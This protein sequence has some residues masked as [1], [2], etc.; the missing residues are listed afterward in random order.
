MG[1]RNHLGVFHFSW[2]KT[3]EV[4]HRAFRRQNQLE[5]A[6]KLL[7]ESA[8]ETSEVL[9]MP[10]WLLPFVLLVVLTAPGCRSAPASAAPI[11]PSPHFAPTVVRAPVA[12]TRSTGT[13]VTVAVTQNHEED[14]TLVNL[15]APD[16]AVEPLAMDGGLRVRG[17]P[18]ADVL[19]RRGV[20]ILAIVEPRDFDGQALREGV[21]A[22]TQVG[23]AV[24]VNGNLPDETGDVDVALV[25][26]LEAAGAITVGPIDRAGLVRGHD[27]EHRQI[28]LFAPYGVSFDRGAVLTAAGVGALVLAA[29]P[30]LGP[31]ALKEHLLDTADGMY[32]AS[33]PDTGG[34]NPQANRIDPQT[35]DFSPTLQAFHF[36]RVNAARAVGAQ[37]DER[38]PVEALNGPAAWKTATGRGVTVAVLDQGFH[39]NNPAFEGRLVDAAAFFP[40]QDFG[41]QQNFHGTAMA[42]IVLAVAPD[43]SLVFL[44]HSGRYDRMAAVIQAYVEAI[45]YAIEKGV[46]VITTSAAPWPNVS[47]VHAAIDR[48]ID[49]GVVFVWFHY[50]GPNDAVIRPGY[51]W[52]PRWEVG[53]FDRF[54][55]D[56]KPSDLEGGFSCT[57]PQIAGVAALI[58]QNEPHLSPGEV[59]QRILETAA[60]LPN[61]NSIVDAAAAVEGRP[62]G[63]RIVTPAAGSFPAGRCQVVYQEP[64]ADERVSIAIEERGQH[65]PVPAWPHRDILFYLELSP[66]GSGDAGDFRLEVY[67]DND[68]WLSAEFPGGRSALAESPARVN[69]LDGKRR[70]GY[71]S[72]TLGEGDVPPLQ[73]E[74]AGD[75]VRLR[76]ESEEGVAMESPRRHGELALPGY[77]LYS[78]EVDVRRLPDFVQ[79]IY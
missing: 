14:T 56:D 63:R 50:S 73:V 75:R 62:S 20:P 54:F 13:G 55:D 52:D 17:K 36:R 60:S 48:A 49:A 53:A 6:S 27:L 35:G 51:F 34:W 45:D 7:E 3:S 42:K 28:N 12:W 57:A 58:L 74:M 64:G 18:L 31:Q 76:W 33:D 1:T 68:L 43:V 21:R 15:M 10:G 59:K 2:R 44:H 41:G 11:L 67:T 32:Q 5:I 46:D 79:T 26:D 47:E 30:T 70:R 78:L 66:V 9:Y 25:N 4:C 29:D 37:L 8:S 69:L 38:W 61:G 77:H 72:A 39:V 24:F 40:G 19:G 22:L 23:V 65:W 16:A 71:Y